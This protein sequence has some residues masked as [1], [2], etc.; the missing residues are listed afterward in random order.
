MGLTG[1]EK[2]LRVGVLSSL[3][4]AGG[5]DSCIQL[6]RV[7]PGRATHALGPHPTP[8]S[9]P[10]AARGTPLW[11]HPCS[12]LPVQCP[13]APVRP[14][15]VSMLLQR[16]SRDRSL[17]MSPPPKPGW[18]P[19]TNPEPEPSGLC[20]LTCP[21]LPSASC[22]LHVSALSLPLCVQCRLWAGW[23]VG[24]WDGSLTKPSAMLPI[25]RNWGDFF[26]IIIIIIF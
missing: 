6:S 15:G 17:L 26:V 24:R 25:W 11:C 8:S 23:A 3:E 21:P 12:L 14:L 16:T 1:A 13:R 5:R 18:P 4:A 9:V 2:R 7:A 19:P 10:S 20:S 22:G